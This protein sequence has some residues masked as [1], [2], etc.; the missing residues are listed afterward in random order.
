MK[1]AIMHALNYTYD[2]PV[3]SSTQYL[4]L[5]PRDTARQKVLD[6]K[7]EAP[8][9]PMRTQDG[10]GN[11]LHV[12][13]VDRPVSE[14]VIRAKGMVETSA[15]LDEPSDF[16][17]ATLSPLVFLRV[18]PLTRA[19]EKLAALAEG[20]RRRTGTL[21]GLRELAAAVHKA[22]PEA[23]AEDVS[24]AFIAC[25]RCLGVPARYVSGYVYS[26]KNGGDERMALHAWAEAWVVDRW[27]SFDV[28]IDYPI[29]EGHIKIAVG[30][31]YLDACPIRGVRTGGGI[32]TLSAQASV[33][34]NQ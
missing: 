28:A 10:Y 23:S 21:S 3:R 15:A 14:I 34:A 12:M 2:A 30:A 22:R 24:Q 20:F 4:R 27:R 26:P 7:L 16:T 17:G 6:W 33:V 13:T 8:G 5:T 1:Y 9:Q 18:T 19:D 32:E 25:C 29:G 11:V 31:D